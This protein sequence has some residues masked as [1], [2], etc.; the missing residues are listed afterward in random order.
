M[1][2]KLNKKLANILMNEVENTS[3]LIIKQKELTNNLIE[4][5]VSDIEEIQL[6]INDET[7]LKGLNNQDTVN[8]YGKRLYELYD[9]IYY[10]RYNSN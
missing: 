4:I 1:I 2:I 3:S 9:E 8:S 6:L 5:E 7:V 10:Q